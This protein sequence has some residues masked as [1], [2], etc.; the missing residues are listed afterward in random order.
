MKKATAF[1]KQMDSKAFTMP[2]CTYTVIVNN[3]NSGL[4]N[5]LVAAMP[6]A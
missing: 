5:K 3:Y 2:Y 1:Y 4:R 6:G